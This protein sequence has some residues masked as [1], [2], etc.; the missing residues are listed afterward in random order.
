M[1]KNGSRTISLWIKSIHSNLRMEAFTSFDVLDYLYVSGTIHPMC[2][3]SAFGLGRPVETTGGTGKRG[4][5][6][7]SEDICTKFENGS[8]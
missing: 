2:T 4:T 3:L 8:A 6:D 7:S 1:L 5:T